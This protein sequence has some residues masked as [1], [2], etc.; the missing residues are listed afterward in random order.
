MTIRYE[1]IAKRAFEIWKKAGGIEGKEQDHWLEAETALRKE[2]L[3][4]Q[5]G[6]KITS[7]D[8]SM[9]KLPKEQAHGS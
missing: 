9:L 3:E 8:A 6:S 4:R 7:K 5:K 2:G 1:D